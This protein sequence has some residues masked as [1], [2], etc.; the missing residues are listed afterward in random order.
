MGK[1]AVMTDTIA[2]IPQEMAEEYGIKVIPYHIVMDGKDYPEMEV[3]REQLYSLLRKKENV[4]TTAAA[5]VGEFLEAYREASGRADSIL[6]ITATLPISATGHEAAIQAKERAAEELPGTVI[7]VIDSRTTVGAQLL[8]VLQAA[9]AA[10]GGKSLREVIEAVSNTISRVSEIDLFTTLFY[11]ER[12]GRI[13]EARALQKSAVDFK[14]II[15]I[16]ASTDGKVTPIGRVRTKAQ[17]VK[18]LLEIMEER[19]KGRRLHVVVDH[20]GIPN[21]AE[22]LKEKVLSR[23]DCAE[24]YVTE[25]ARIAAIHNGLGVLHLGFYSED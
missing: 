3:D 24:L 2:G 18:R 1:V 25:S 6:H 20:I 9:R 13:G 16:D 4:P 11:L 10:A 5:S 7:E 23:F 12:G 15:E 22:K 17:G 19:N 21:D 14:P 8:V